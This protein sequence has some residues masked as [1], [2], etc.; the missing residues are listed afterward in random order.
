VQGRT[1]NP[2][3]AVLGMTVAALAVVGVLGLLAAQSVPEPRPAAPAGAAKPLP[4]QTPAMQTPATQRQPADSVAL[5]A[6]SG[7]GRRIVYAVGIRR[8]WVVG[9]SG[10]PVRTYRVPR[11]QP[12]V[13]A[14]TYTVDAKRRSQPAS[15]PEYRVRY[16]LRTG[17]GTDGDSG[18][19]FCSVPLT[20][21][22]RPARPAPPGD[23]AAAGLPCIQ[24]KLADARY[25]WRAARVGTTVVV[26]P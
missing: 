19:G 20:P 5:P 10:Q 7:T 25:L 11:G 15:Q 8:I 16:V 3:V 23:T 1:I 18:P 13:A 9:T 17:P 12:P 14:G 22:G 6:G 4:G 24:Q 21:S 2:L 26:V